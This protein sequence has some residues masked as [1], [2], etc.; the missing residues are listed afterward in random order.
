MHGRVNSNQT[1]LA[2]WSKVAFGLPSIYPL[3]YG[4]YRDAFG[5]DSPLKED[6]KESCNW[7]DCEQSLFFVCFV[8]LSQ[9]IVIP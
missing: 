3:G 4:C 8:A 1:N 9:A 6:V 5:L 2:R 7:K